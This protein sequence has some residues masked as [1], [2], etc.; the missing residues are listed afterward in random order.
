MASQVTERYK[1]IPLKNKPS[2][3]AHEQIIHIRENINAKQ[4]HAKMLTFPN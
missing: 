1:K 2:T 3:D 4:T